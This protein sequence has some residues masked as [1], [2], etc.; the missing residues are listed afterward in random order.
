MRQRL[1]SIGGQGCNF[2]L[3][4]N[5]ILSTS[6]TTNVARAWVQCVVKQVTCESTGLGESDGQHMIEFD[7]CFTIIRLYKIDIFVYINNMR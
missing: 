2:D 5:V 1:L 4:R 3:I 7:S 6:I